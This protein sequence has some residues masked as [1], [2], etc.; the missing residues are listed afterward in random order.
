MKKTLTSIALAFL[1]ASGLNAQTTD[2]EWVQ[3]I[4]GSLTDIGRVIVNDDSG[5]LYLIGQYQDMVDFDPGPGTTELTSNGGSDVYVLKLDANG[6]LIWAKSMG[7]ANTEF[8]KSIVVDGNGNVYVTGSFEGTADF[9][10]GTGTTNL[11]SNGNDD[12]FIAKLDANG[13][14]VW[15][16]SMGDVS[17]DVPFC[18]TLDGSGNVYT[19]GKYKGTVD[20]DPGAG[21]MPLTAAGD[22]DAF[23]QKLDANGV[24]VWAKSMGGVDEDEVYGMMTDASENVYLA[25]PTRKFLFNPH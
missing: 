11:I 22:F 2:F 1:L 4:G 16:V 15:A 19:A 24:F 7:G 8:A 14:F 13:D 20:F 12:V 3:S 9:D 10:P 18:M 17:D 21:S 6:D 25:G 23:V 5:N